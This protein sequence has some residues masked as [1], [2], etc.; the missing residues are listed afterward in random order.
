MLLAGALAGAILSHRPLAPLAL[1]GGAL[2]ALWGLGVGIGSDSAT[3]AVG[4]AA[5]AAINVGIGA[6]V[7]AGWRAL[8]ARQ[9]PTASGQARHH[10][11]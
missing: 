5:L 11:R 3:V 1:V 6:V 7:G 9:R 4:G 10:S 8:V 2:S